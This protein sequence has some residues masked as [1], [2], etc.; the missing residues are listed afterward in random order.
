LNIKTLQSMTK[1]NHININQKRYQLQIK[2]LK[3]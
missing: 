3:Y 1:L 2:H